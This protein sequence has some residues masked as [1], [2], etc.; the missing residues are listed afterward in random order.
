MCCQV[1]GE[2]GPCRMVLRVVGA[3]GAVGLDPL[4]LT[5]LDVVAGG[6]PGMG[7][8]VFVL[9]PRYS[10]GR[11]E[12]LEVEKVVADACRWLGGM[13]DGSMRFVSDL[14]SRRRWAARSRAS[15]P[16]EVRVEVLNCC[17]LFF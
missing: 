10:R 8:V 6:A 11:V 4:R 13:V 1:G 3:V 15:C 12:H 16:D 17:V 14:G 9:V 5:G 7:R 2:S